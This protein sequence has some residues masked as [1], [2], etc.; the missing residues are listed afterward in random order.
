MRY[1]LEFIYIKTSRIGE[2]CSVRAGGGGGHNFLLT[3]YLKKGN[4]FQDPRCEDIFIGTIFIHFLLK[5]SGE[6]YVTTDFSG[7]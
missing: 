5:F 2:I 7:G 3:S 6:F 1:K 4:Y